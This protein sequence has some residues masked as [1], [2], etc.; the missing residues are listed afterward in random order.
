MIGQGESFD[1]KLLS[2]VSDGI[3]LENNRFFEAF[4]SHCEDTSNSEIRNCMNITEHT[5]GIV[6]MLKITTL[7]KAVC[8][9]TDSN[10]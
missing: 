4:W 5:V 3:V 1:Q 7:L 2:Q 8:K 6:F 9:A 10:L